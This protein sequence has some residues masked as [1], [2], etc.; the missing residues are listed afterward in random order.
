MGTKLSY[1]NQNHN[2]NN[3]NNNNNVM[4]RF[5]FYLGGKSVDSFPKSK[6]NMLQN[7]LISFFLSF[8]LKK[9]K[10]DSNNIKS[11]RLLSANLAC[12]LASAK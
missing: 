7:I 5:Q 6:G 3:N 1:Q 11:G 4:K 10:G 9:K 8:A 12:R 2:N